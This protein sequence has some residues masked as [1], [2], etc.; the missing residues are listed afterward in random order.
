LSE[1]KVLVTEPAD[2]QSEKPKQ[3]NLTMLPSVLVRA[4]KVIK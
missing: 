2:H 4:N 1:Q 3:I